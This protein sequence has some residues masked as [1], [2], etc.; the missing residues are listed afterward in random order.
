MFRPIDPETRR[1]VCPFCGAQSYLDSRNPGRHK[2]WRIVCL[3]EDAAT[4]FSKRNLVEIA[5]SNA[6]VKRLNGN[7]QVE[8]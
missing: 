2:T 8:W 7:Q 3:N 6:R 1:K 5:W 4:R